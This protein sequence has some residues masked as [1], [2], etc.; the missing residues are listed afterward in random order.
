MVGHWL[1][2][3]PPPPP[4]PPAAEVDRDLDEMVRGVAPLLSSTARRYA[5]GKMPTVAA[6]GLCELP[7]RPDPAQHCV[8]WAGVSGDPEGNWVA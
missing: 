5:P 8:D 6:C 2:V 1:R 3:A 7:C 4:Q